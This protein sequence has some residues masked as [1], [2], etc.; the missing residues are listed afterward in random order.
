VLKEALYVGFIG[1]IVAVISIYSL[2]NNFSIGPMILALGLLP[3]LGILFSN[4]KLSASTPD[5][6]FGAIDT[7][8]LVIPAIA[9]GH[10]YGIVGAVAGGVIGDAITDSVAGFFEGGIARWLR[11]HGIAESRDPISTSLGKMA[12]CLVGAGIVMSVASLIG[13]SL[14]G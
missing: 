12:G 5:M 10:Y 9:G 7:G 4:R 13:I 14:A 1:I 2:K 8:M 3:V 11:D 6:L